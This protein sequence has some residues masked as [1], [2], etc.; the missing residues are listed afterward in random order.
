MSVPIRFYYPCI[1]RRNSA[2]AVQN[3]MS[4]HSTSLR[5][6]TYQVNATDMPTSASSDSESSDKRKTAL[7]HLVKKDLWARIAVKGRFETNAVIILNDS[8]LS[9]CDLSLHPKYSCFI[10]SDR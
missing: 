7:P 1:S 3:Q 4:A 9:L 10:E 8:L 5:L 6:F 2:N